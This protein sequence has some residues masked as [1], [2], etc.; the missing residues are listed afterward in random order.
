MRKFHLTFSLITL[1]ALIIATALG[2]QNPLLWLTSG[3]AGMQII[4][5]VTVLFIGAQLLTTPPRA[6]VLR[7]ATLTMALVSGAA[8]FYSF[9]AVG[10]PFLDALLFGHAAITL[11]ISA[12]ELKSLTYTEKA[13]A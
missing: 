8:S 4:R 10:S 6:M 11:T 2:S 5:A 1:S 13:L 9:T 3:E 7:T 12:L